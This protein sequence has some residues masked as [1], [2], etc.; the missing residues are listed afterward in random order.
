[1]KLDKRYLVGRKRSDTYVAKFA[2]FFNHN[3]KPNTI[4]ELLREQNMKKM[5]QTENK[6]NVVV[7][8]KQPKLT[9]FIVN[10]VGNNIDFGVVKF[11]T[12][13]KNL[14]NLRKLRNDSNSQNARAS[15]YLYCK[16]LN[17]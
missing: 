7:Q 11:I 5:S 15:L 3:I 17:V 4:L 13:Q 2:Q 6:I 8:P 1:M 14:N 9:H 10:D 12:I 16:M